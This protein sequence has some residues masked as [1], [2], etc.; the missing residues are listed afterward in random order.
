LRVPTP[1]VSLVDLVVDVEKEVSV[2][3]VNEAF[4]QAA[5]KGMAGIIK[6]S[7]DPLVSIDY[8]TTDY[9]AII[10]ALSTIVMEDNKI[11]I[12][13]WYDNE[14]AYSAR[15]V[16]VAKLVGESLNE[17]QEKQKVKIS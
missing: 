2:E 13:A 14:S 8:A 12:L 11:K 17:V 7:E 6:Y 5:E 16:G 1:N 10:D 3:E 15:V 4:K 9:S